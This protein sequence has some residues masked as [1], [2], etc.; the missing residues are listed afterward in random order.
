MDN[1][2]IALVN[3]V[4]SLIAE[5][6]FHLWVRFY[7]EDFSYCTFTEM[8]AIGFQNWFD[9]AWIILAFFVEFCL[10]SSSWNLRGLKP[11]RIE[12][13]CFSFD[14]MQS[15][16]ALCWG[17]FWSVLWICLQFL[18][19]AF[20]N[21]DWWALSMQTSFTFFVCASFIMIFLQQVTNF[22][23]DFF[24][25]PIDPFL[26]FLSI[27]TVFW[28]STPFTGVVIFQFNY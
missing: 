15:F 11:A 23:F 26:P 20:S 8:F 6:L 17:E 3:I 14:D 25:I 2:F 18:A 9:T 13:L 10:I 27:L 12:H 21:I 1:F 16:R 4:A 22:F 19:M 24:L 28:C 7:V 5:K